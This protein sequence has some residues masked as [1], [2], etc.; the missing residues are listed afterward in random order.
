LKAVFP[1]FFTGPTIKLLTL[2][3]FNTQVAFNESKLVAEET[4][5]PLVK[6]NELSNVTGL[7]KVTTPLG[8]LINNFPIAKLAV[9]ENV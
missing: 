2:P 8:L 9:P 4:N 1:V 7:A 3:P 6:V 5:L